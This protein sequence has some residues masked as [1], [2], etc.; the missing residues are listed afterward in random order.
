MI[1]WCVRHLRREG[2]QSNAK[3]S[4]GGAKLKCPALFLRAGMGAFIAAFLVPTLAFDVKSQAIDAFTVADIH[5]DV[6]AKTAAA[7]RKL[8]LPDG[9]KRAFEFLLKRLTMR[10]DHKRLPV[11]PAKEISSYVQDFGVKNEKNSQV[12]YLADLSYRFKPRD[13]RFLLRDSD[14]QF[15]E[16]ISK[17]ILVLPVYQVAGAASLWDDPNPW[18]QAWINRP[19][20]DGLVPMIFAAG[21]LADIAMIG[22]ELAVKGDEQRLA[23]IARRYQVATTLVVLGTLSSTKRGRPV[24]KVAIFRYGKNES[25]EAFS[26]EI[27]TTPGE[28]IDGLLKRAAI[29]IGAQIEDKWKSDNL[30]KFERLGVVAVTLPIKS[31]GEWVDAKRRL[32]RVAVIEN[33]ELVLLSRSEV[34]INI[35]FI[36]E[37]G[38]L[39][40]ALAQSDM[41]LTEEQGSWIVKL[42]PRVKS[43]ATKRVKNK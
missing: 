33:A 37:A 4:D 34:R 11:L 18:R 28:G 41:V 31:L 25:R 23:A 5:V 6:T 3:E 10:I 42:Q 1:L 12:R 8:A 13:I 15:A 19:I 36:G 35:H 40:L 24:L 32:A 14:I 29:E 17:P 20:V 26:A 2:W 16:T 27:Y 39:K 43:G 21:D 30:L 38:Q 7:A 22:A 9:E